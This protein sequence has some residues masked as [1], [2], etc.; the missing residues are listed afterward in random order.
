MTTMR[1]ISQD[2]ITDA[3]WQA[4]CDLAALYRMLDLLGWTDLIYG[5]ASARIPGESNHFLINAF[6]QTCNEITA[7]SL[8]KMDLDGNTLT[9][10][11]HTNQAGYVIH[12]GVYKS[13]PDANCAIHT[14]TRNGS[15]LSLLANGIRP[16]SQPAM[17]V[18]DDLAYHTY[19]IPASDEECEPGRAPQSRP[20]DACADDQGRIV[21]TLYA[22]GS[23]RA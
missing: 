8:V 23:V 1:K 21:A 9:P 15:G 11:G 2:S 6:G 7:S 13:R 3:E 18:I 14:H 4:R 16:I 5:H 19:G 20:A 10:G 17:H 22:G 12:S